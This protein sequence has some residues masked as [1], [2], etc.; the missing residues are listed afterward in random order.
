MKARWTLIIV[1]A[2]LA[3]GACM[4]QATPTP[5]IT[6]AEPTPVID[7]G[8]S[9]SA[10]V[11][12]LDTIQLG[13]T[14]VGRA[15]AVNVKVG[16]QVTAGQV[17]VQLDTTI[18]EAQVKEAEFDLAALETQLSKLTR[19]VASER[20]RDIARANVESSKARLESIKA[21][22]ANS[23]LATPVGGTVTSVDI[24]VGET[25]TP[26]RALI[27]I[28]D[29]SKFRIETTDLSEVD[30][31][32][33]KVGQNATVYIEALDREITGK[34]LEIAQQSETVGGDVVFKV[35]IELDEQPEGLRWG[36]SAEVTLEE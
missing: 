17:L 13:F 12:P 26:G 16:D 8:V 2:M 4:P 33:V 11:V 32:K 31:P 30:I 24:S 35:T 29:L 28:A 14:T 21:Q 7:A 27:T 1:I 20:D 6:E 36:M 23:T 9:A 3:L 22:L 10:V 15:T 5:S 25:A 19:N 34:V 18:I